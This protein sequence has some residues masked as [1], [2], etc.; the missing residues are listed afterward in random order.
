M[1]FNSPVFLFT[2]FPIVFLI[3]FALGGLGLRRLAS[4]WLCVS[5]LAFYG[6]DD[7]AMHRVVSAHAP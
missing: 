5:S 2:F 7:H 4:A 1:L 6:W 3:F